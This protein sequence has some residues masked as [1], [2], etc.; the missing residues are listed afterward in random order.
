MPPTVLIAGIGNIFLGDDGFGSEVAR[1]LAGRSW[2]AGVRVVDY[3]I[4]GFDVAFALMDGVDVAI[5][6]DATPQ[7]GPPGT[8]YVIEPDLGALNDPS[9]KELPVDTHAMNPMKVFQLVR[10]MDGRFNR[11]LIVGCEPADFGPENE[12]R[13]GLSPA[14]A[15]G[16]EE[17]IRVVDRLVAEILCYNE[18]ADAVRSGSNT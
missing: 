17:A 5:L 16:V 14:V 15:A 2:P 6:V 3:G 18:P 13:I 1:R 9:V 4:R 7:G 10:A 12:G 11:V 8:V